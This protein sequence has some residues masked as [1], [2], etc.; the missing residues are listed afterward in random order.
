MALGTACLATNATCIPEVIKEG[1]TGCMVPQK[2]PEA[3]ADAIQKLMNDHALR[4]R[5]ARGARDIIEAEF[6][7]R[8]TTHQLREL[9]R[10]ETAYVRQVIREAC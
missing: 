2:N 10:V 1:E 3:L 4:L 5:L 7:S 6:D 8:G 9:F